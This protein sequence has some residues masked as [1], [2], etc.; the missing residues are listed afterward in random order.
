[1]D[2]S[3]EHSKSFADF[4]VQRHARGPGGESCGG[5]ETD[6][7]LVDDLEF[8][9]IMSQTGV[10]KVVPKVVPKVVAWGRIE[11]VELRN[12]DES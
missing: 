6:E 11:M 12:G 4:A 9:F 7:M 3:E 8:G 10:V 2:V 1:M 5:G